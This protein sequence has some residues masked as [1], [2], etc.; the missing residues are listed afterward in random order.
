MKTKLA[1][2]FLIAG[3]LLL[4]VAGHTADSDADRSSPKAFVKDSAITAKIKTELAK[5]KMSSLVHIS[6]DTDKNGVVSLSGSA[7]SKNAVDKAVSIARA[8]PGVTNVQSSIQIK[9]DK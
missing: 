7:A 3:A 6:V 2:S 5:E 4:P 9:A 8:V 1:A